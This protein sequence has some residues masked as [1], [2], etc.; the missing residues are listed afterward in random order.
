MVAST[1]MTKTPR[2]MTASAAIGRFRKIGKAGSLLMDKTLKL[3]DK[4][5][6]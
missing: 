3:T 5:I 1:L 6:K 2:Q 4:E